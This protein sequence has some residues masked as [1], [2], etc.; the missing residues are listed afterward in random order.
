[1]TTA[2]ITEYE[3]ILKKLPHLSL[4][5]KK[6][7]IVELEDQILDSYRGDDQMWAG[8]AEREAEREAENAGRGS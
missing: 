3:E 5:Q 4:Q 8:I 6:R 7:V 1:M 2:T